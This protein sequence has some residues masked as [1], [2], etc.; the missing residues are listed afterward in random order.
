ML[1]KI[2]VGRSD[3]FKVFLLL[4]FLYTKSMWNTEPKS[5]KI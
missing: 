4:F 2:R 3:F 5:S 1:Q